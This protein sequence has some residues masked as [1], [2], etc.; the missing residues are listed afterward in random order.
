MSV[1]E[2]SV[3]PKLN[4]MTWTAFPITVFIALYIAET[5]YARQNIPTINN[6]AERS[7]RTHAPRTNAVTN[8]AYHLDD[9]TAWGLDEQDWLRYQSWLNGPRGLWT[10][11]LDPLLVLGIHASSE[12]ERTRFANAFVDMEFTRVE[13]EIRFQ[14]TVNHVLEER[15]KHTSAHSPQGRQLVL[16]ANLDC[17]HDCANLLAKAQSMVAHEGTQLSVYLAGAHN[18]QAVRDWALARRVNPQ[19][20]YAQRVQLN[21]DGGHW[22]RVRQSHVH[23]QQEHLPQLLA[24]NQDGRYQSL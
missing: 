9:Y 8:R 18:D 11:D 3:R 14:K 1:S 23:L 5:S 4:V 21:H 10:P 24:R 12:S 22:D 15:F 19:W 2:V 7:V 6:T 13:A 16:F 17:K 20:V